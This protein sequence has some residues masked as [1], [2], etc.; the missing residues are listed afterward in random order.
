MTAEPGKIVRLQL[1]P[2]QQARIKQATGHAAEALDLTVEELEE[3][4][5]PR[6]IGNHN[7]P[8]LTGAPGTLLSRNQP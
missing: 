7:E 2:E 6:I 8:L 4:I 5:T 3:R 1:T